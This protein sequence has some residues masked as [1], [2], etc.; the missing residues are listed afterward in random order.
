MP[1]AV[2]PM[3]RQLRAQAQSVAAQE[4]D[5]RGQV[6]KVDTFAN[7]IN[8]SITGTIIGKLQ[9]ELDARPTFP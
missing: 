8:N 6:E 5:V 3:A 7:Q 1:R 9:D 2:L 4:R